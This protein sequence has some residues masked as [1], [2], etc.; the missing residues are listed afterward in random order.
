MQP[1]NLPLGCASKSKFSEDLLTVYPGRWGCSGATD[2]AILIDGFYAIAGE[3]GKL[4]IGA[5]VR[6]LAERAGGVFNQHG[7]QGHKAIV[8][9]RLRAFSPASTQE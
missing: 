2:R 4:H 8:C 9:G 6:T 1:K 3:T 7:F 5:A